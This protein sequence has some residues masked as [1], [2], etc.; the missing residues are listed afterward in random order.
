MTSTSP[1]CP[2]NEVPVFF[3]AGEEMLFGIFTEP[4]DAR[5]IAVIHAR[6]G[7]QVPSCGRNGTTAR[8]C[9]RLAGDGYHTLRFDYRGVGESTGSVT[10]FRHD[11]PF[12]SDLEGGIAW[13]RARGIE[14]FVVIGQCFGAR[15]ALA[16]G[17]FPG[18]EGLVL[19]STPV[20]DSAKE[21]DNTRALVRHHRLGRYVLRAIGP[22][23][24][25]D[26]RS[27]S[28]RE[29]FVRAAHAVLRASPVPRGTTTG[30][31]WVSAAFLEQ[32]ECLI[33]SGIPILF[34]SGRADSTFRDFQVALVGRLGGLL[35][36][37]GKRVTITTLDGQL[38]ACA[39]AD[40][41]DTA[42][43]TIARWLSAEVQRRRGPLAEHPRAGSR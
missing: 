14:R 42:I 29:Q 27:R 17:W 16:E 26:L 22:R 20:R 9:R 13:L 38:S 8:L 33:G 40:L 18:L 35:E 32:V 6:G 36:Q 11:Q 25:R 19:L 4:F 10:T 23:S 3:Q 7:G 28:G 37:G 1:V 15:T 30:P 21:G 43:E 12:V 2:S 24:L 31:A 5:G 39:D 41:Q 34:A